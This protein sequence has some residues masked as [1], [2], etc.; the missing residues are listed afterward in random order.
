M[1]YTH[2]NTSQDDGEPSPTLSMLSD[3]VAASTPNLTESFSTMS[4][5]STPSSKFSTMQNPRT[6]SYTNAAPTSVDGNVFRYD[7]HEQVS[8]IYDDSQFDRG[9]STP[10]RF[11]VDAPAVDRKLKPRVPEKRSKDSSRPVSILST[12]SINSIQSVA[13]PII[14][15]KLK[16]ATPQKVKKSKTNLLALMMEL[17]EFF[18]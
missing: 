4:V 1:P 15:R 12:A 14:N 9:N 10:D 3:A 17:I 18:V 2:L 16:P 11:Q 5:A 13:G 7:F 6:H 8:R